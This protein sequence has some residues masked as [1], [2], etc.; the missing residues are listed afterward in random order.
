M[1]HGEFRRWSTHVR[2]GFGKGADALV[3]P[4]ENFKIETFLLCAKHHASEK[5]PVVTK[6]HRSKV[7]CR[8]NT[9]RSQEKGTKLFTGI[10]G[11]ELTGTDG[12]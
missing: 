6:S 2:V 5:T 10:T 8:T 7:K 4:S 3:R 9:G 12:P 11:S 1:L